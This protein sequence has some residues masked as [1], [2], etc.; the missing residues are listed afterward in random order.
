MIGYSDVTCFDDLMKKQNQYL[1]QKYFN[2][3]QTKHN[4]ES[5]I[6][7]SKELSLVDNYFNKMKDQM[8]FDTINEIFFNDKEE[9]YPEILNGKSYD[10]QNIVSTLKSFI[11]TKYPLK[12]GQN[13]PLDNIGE[14]SELSQN[15]KK[16]PKIINCN[17]PRRFYKIF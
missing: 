4:N 13:S 6:N 5:L 16:Y 11:N 12:E 1:Q 10:V 14:I 8:S 17:D 2:G 15:I 7:P 3:L 9:L